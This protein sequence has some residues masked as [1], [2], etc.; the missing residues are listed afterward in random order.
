MEAMTT[1]EYKFLEQVPNE[2]RRLNANIEALI[3]FL[4]SQSESKDSN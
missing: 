4:K 3:A 1:A 2:L